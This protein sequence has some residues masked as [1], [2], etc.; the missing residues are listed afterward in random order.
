MEWFNK[1]FKS[2]YLEIDILI[3]NQY[4]RKN[5]IDWENDKCVICKMPL[6]I[7]P[8]NHKSS[9]NEMT[10]G[11]FF[12][13]F[14]H[15]FLRNIYSYDELTQSEDICSLEN[16]YTA[17]DVDDD[18]DKLKSNIE[19]IEIKNY[20]KSN[21]IPKF[22]LKLYALVYNSL[23][24]FPRSK[25][26]Y[27]T[28]TTTNFFGNVHK[29]IKVKIDLHHSHITGEIFGYSHDFCNWK[30]EESK[31]EILLIAQNLFGFDMFCFIKGYRA[32][33]WGS[34]DLNFGG[35]NLTNINSGNIGNEIKF[36]DT[37]KYYQKSL[38]ELAS[39]LTENENKSVKTS[40]LQFLNQHHYFGEIWKFLSDVQ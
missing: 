35:N 30:V 10:Y 4:E 13:R 11:V 20:V 37:L 32:S 34:K 38:G 1:K 16:Y 5:P 9:N 17:Y 25:F 29:Y 6:K 2:Q 28:I 31:N 36:V 15:K 33:A 19:L 23:I 18:I 3:K 39:T 12:I 24:E 40:V 27:E 14:E 22:N 26:N 7:D 8:T 21:K